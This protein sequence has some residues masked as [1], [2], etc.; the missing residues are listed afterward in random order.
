VDLPLTP[1]ELAARLHMDDPFDAGRGELEVESLDVHETDFALALL[2]VHV[3]PL[4]GSHRWRVLLPI[5]ESDLDSEIS[6]EAFTATVR[7][8]L[9]EWWDLKDIDEEHAAMGSRLD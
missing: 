7:A 2:V 3:H 5:D 1:D 4:H 9:R 8:N 6:A